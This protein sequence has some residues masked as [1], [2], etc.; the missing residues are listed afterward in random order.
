MR[1]IDNMSKKTCIIVAKIKIRCLDNMN[2]ERKKH[3][4]SELI[5]L[6]KA[7]IEQLDY[8]KDYKT[9]FRK[10]MDSDVVSVSFKEK[11]IVKFVFFVSEKR[12]NGLIC[13]SGRI[14]I[15]RKK[16][17]NWYFERT[18]TIYVNEYFYCG[19]G[20]LDKAL[21]DVFDEYFP[22]K[23]QCEIDKIIQT[24]KDN[25]ITYSAVKYN[26]Y[27]KKYTISIN[28]NEILNFPQEEISEDIFIYKYMPLKTYYLMIEKAS[29]RMN[30][31]VSMNDKTESFFI[32]DFIYGEVEGNKNGDDRYKTL[33]QNKNTLIS[34]FSDK[35]NG[36]MWR[37]YA[38]DYR[39]V[40]L[41]FKTKRNRV[42]RII[43]INE[44]NEKC[45]LL[46]DIVNS[47]SNDGIHII[48]A[49]FDDMKCFVKQSVYNIEDEYRILQDETNDNLE[50]AYY[51][52][53]LC[54][55]KD[56]KY[57]KEKYHFDEIGIMPVS[58][59]I[60]H[61]VPNLDVN[62]PLLTNLSYEVFRITDITR[63]RNDSLRV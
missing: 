25:K 38:D 3:E 60:G 4:F 1:T 35:N 59:V 58:L 37:L 6:L 44:N 54:H 8:S 45:L 41:G 12:S 31:I 62:Y 49:D 10:E 24:L 56:Y 29:F 47:L 33:L 36:I 63:N 52:G 34:A 55:Y 28:L 20:L 2:F 57:N 40:C 16:T 15:P 14:T 7:R 18:D 51:D 30:S 5:D 11:L 50:I 23:Q 61:N 53:L 27:L 9:D 43:Y 13:L 21:S 22:L 46:K 39:G 48:Y 42:K 19:N 26:S 32:N 17:P